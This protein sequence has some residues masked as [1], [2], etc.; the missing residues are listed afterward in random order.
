MLDIYQIASCE[1]GLNTSETELATIVLSKITSLLKTHPS[2]E[3]S[4][5]PELQ[6]LQ[7]FPTHRL[8]TCFVMSTE[9]PQTNLFEKRFLQK[10]KA[11]VHH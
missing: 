7:E 6:I 9:Q 11:N 3:L 5:F 8:P 4:L 2:W 1:N 10:M